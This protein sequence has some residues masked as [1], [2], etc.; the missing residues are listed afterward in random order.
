MTY[1]KTELL[2][3]LDMF[4][5]L[6]T[7]NDASFVGR[8]E[9]CGEA[10]HDVDI[11]LVLNPPVDWQSKTPQELA[12]IVEQYL[13]DIVDAIGQKDNT[14]RAMSYIGT[15][16]LDWLGYNFGVEFPTNVSFCN[17]DGIWLDLFWTTDALSS[18]INHDYFAD[19]VLWRIEGGCP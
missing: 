7:V 13:N 5:A 12:V 11:L 2:Y 9:L 4:K 17:P 6:P 16:N 10:E 15:G 1:I 3:L 8:I 19:K 18:A 14:E